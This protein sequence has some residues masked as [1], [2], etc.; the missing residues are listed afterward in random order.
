VFRGG[1]GVF[2]VI[3]ECLEEVI[4]CLRWIWCV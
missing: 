1:Y 2:E 4:G 3:I